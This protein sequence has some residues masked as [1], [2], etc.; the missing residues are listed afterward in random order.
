MIP[1]GLLAFGSYPDDGTEFRM[2][3][4]PAMDFQKMSREATPSGY[5]DSDRSRN[6]EICLDDWGRDPSLSGKRLDAVIPSQ[7][8]LH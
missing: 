6:E 1:A 4:L 2:A 3:I 7:K 8:D 5:F